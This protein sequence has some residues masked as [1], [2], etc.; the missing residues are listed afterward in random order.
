MTEKWLDL[1]LFEGDG[2]GAAPAAGEGAG[3]EAAAVTPGTTQDG[4]RIDNR[5]AARMERLAQKRAA[6][7]ETSLA[8]M[9]QAQATQAPSEPAATEPQEGPNLDDEWA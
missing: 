6:R 4:T 8:G 1:H 9:N 3:A 5:L 2:A 7:G